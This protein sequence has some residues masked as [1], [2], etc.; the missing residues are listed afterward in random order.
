M[1]SICERIDANHNVV[2]SLFMEI[3]SS[4][5]FSRW[6][7]GFSNECSTEYP[8]T[9]PLDYCSFIPGLAYGMLVGV[10]PSYGLITGIIGPFVYALF[11]TSK[12]ASP[13]SFAIVSL[14]V[15]AVVESFGHSVSI[16]EVDSIPNITEEFCCRE[17]KPKVSD[18]DAIAIATS[19]TL[20]AGLFQ[21]LFGLMNAGL[22]AVWLSDQLVQG[23]ISGAAVHVLTSQLKSMTGV[24]NVPPTSEPFQ[25]MQVFHI[26]KILRS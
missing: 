4:I 21:I 17:N 20:L 7:N 22:L 16:D 14:M 8:S 3:E 5:R 26:F 2:T 1:V 6:I 18:S 10:P 15:G 23:L 9:V 13:G 25:H 11:G 12:H 19:V 24:T